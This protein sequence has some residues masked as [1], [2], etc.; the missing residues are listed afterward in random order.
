MEFYQEHFLDTIKILEDED[1]DI[2][3]LA[4]KTKFDI[5]DFYVGADFAGCSL[6]GFDLRGLNFAHASFRGATLTGIQYDEGAFN[7]SLLDDT[8]S[9]IKDEFDLT[10]DEFMFCY[11]KTLWVHYYVA[12]R[13]SSLERA[14]YESD[15]TFR[16]FAQTANIN[17]ATLRGARR[18]YMVARETAHGICAAMLAHIGQTRDRRTLLGERDTRWHL[19]PILK[20]A[21]SY[22]EGAPKTI[23]KEQMLSL[24]REYR[25]EHGPHPEE[26]II[27]QTRLV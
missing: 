4:K 14:I 2:Y 3:V 6:S 23:Q 16:S 25:D 15:I 24:S 22:E 11:D 19:Q 27:R 5:F 12:F 7:E 26:G 21:E 1:Q 17:T 20:F 10:V 18:G 13:P 9:V 8:H